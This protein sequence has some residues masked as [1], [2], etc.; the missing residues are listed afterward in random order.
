MGDVLYEVSGAIYRIDDPFI[1]GACCVDILRSF[2]AAE[3]MTG[4]CGFQRVD[5]GVFHLII[6]IRHV[7]IP[8]LVADFNQ[9]RAVKGA[10]NAGRHKACGA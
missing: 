2:F 4:E 5:N 8:A 9:V 3:R 10:G 1:F 6:D 7:V